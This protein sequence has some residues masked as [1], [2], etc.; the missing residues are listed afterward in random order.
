M[1]II[2]FNV[3]IVQKGM[4]SVVDN[5][6]LIGSILCSQEGLIIVDTFGFNSIYNTETISAMA[7]SMINEHNY[8]YI[9]PIGI[10][11]IYETEKIVIRNINCENKNNEFLLISLIPEKMRYYKRHINKLE[12]I[13]LKNL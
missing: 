9:P 13:I 3:D 10:I 11:L 12:N 4:Q 2:N 6:N 5:T 7:A 1:K 8:G